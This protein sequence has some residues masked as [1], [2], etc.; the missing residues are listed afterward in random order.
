MC[1][2]S[3][4]VR[5]CFAAIARHFGEAS[6]KCVHVRVEKLSNTRMGAYNVEPYYQ[7]PP[8]FLVVFLAEARKRG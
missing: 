6:V 2:T 3:H 5:R 7:A 4:Y 1:K 8:S